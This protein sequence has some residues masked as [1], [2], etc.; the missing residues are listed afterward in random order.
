MRGSENNSTSAFIAASKVGGAGSSILKLSATD[1]LMT[2]LLVGL[3]RD[4][5]AS[6]RFFAARTAP[7]SV[8]VKS[9]ASCTSLRI[10][11]ILVR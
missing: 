6:R 11:R 4:S 8:A 3:Q 1:S 9:L 7:R 10:A 5:V 2:Q